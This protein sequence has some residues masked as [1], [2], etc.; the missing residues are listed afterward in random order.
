[1]QVNDGWLEPL[2]HTLRSKPRAVATPL[3]HMSSEQ[4]YAEHSRTLADPYYIRMQKGFGVLDALL[5]QGSASGRRWESYPSSSMLGGAIAGYKTVLEEL[6]PEGLMGHSWG[7]E[8]NRLAFRVWMCGE[9]VWMCP[10]S[11]VTG[12][13]FCNLHLRHFSY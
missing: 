1:M 7:V 6:Y 11:Q 2:L 3:I 13:S 4:N 12:L 9:G 5:T 10:C 8:N